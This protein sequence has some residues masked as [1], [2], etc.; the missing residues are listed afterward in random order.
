VCACERAC[1]CVR[2]RV[3]MCAYVCVCM[4]VREKINIFTVDTGGTYACIAVCRC[5][6]KCGA[7]SRATI[8]EDPKKKKSHSRLMSKAV[9]TCHD[10]LS[11]SIGLSFTRTFKHTN[12][13]VESGSCKNWKKKKTGAKKKEGYK[14]D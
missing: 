5:A 1:V 8:R 3:R 7:E 12:W 6:T 2:V 4:C 10:I 9:K 13:G 14:S 11:I